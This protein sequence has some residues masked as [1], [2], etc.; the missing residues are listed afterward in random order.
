MAK[1]LTVRRSRPYSRAIHAIE[2]PCSIRRRIRRG[3][4]GCALSIDTRGQLARVPVGIQRHPCGRRVGRCTL[5]L[6]VRRLGGRCAQAVVVSSDRPINRL[7]R[8]FLQQ[9]PNLRL[10]S[11]HAIRGQ[12]SAELPTSPAPAVPRRAAITIARRRPAD[13]QHVGHST[14]RF[15]RAPGGLED[16]ARLSGLVA[17]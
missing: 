1:R 4:R 12:R 3:I 5:L 15:A 17:R 8:R 14:Q 10:A 2:W 16:L 9:R 13:R 6:R 7:G 11:R